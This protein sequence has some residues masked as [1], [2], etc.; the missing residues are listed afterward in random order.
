MMPCFLSSHKGPTPK[1]KA[2]SASGA[3][4]SKN[5]GIASCGAGAANGGYAFD[6][7]NTE[8][9]FQRECWFVDSSHSAMS[10]CPGSIGYL[11]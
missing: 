2:M 6:L 10:G 1:A 11:P 4:A 8:A 7:R 3:S 5:D 9:A